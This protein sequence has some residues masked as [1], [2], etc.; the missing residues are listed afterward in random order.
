MVGIMGRIHPTAII[1][2]GALLADDVEIGPYCIIDS[3]NVRIGAGTRL[4]ANVHITGNVTIG[5]GNLIYPYAAIGFEPQDRKFSL[6]R[7]SAGVKIGNNNVLREGVTIHCATQAKP[8]TLGDDNFLM[9]Y[10]HLGH[11][12]QM[13]NC[14]TLANSTLLAG[15]VEV[16]NNVVTGGGSVVHQF[17]RLGRLA[18]LSGVAGIV[19]DLPPFCTCYST[20]FVESLNIVGLRRAGC[21]DHIPALKQAFEILYRGRHTLPTAADQIEHELG[22]DP[23]CQEFAAFVRSSKRGITPYRD[24]QTAEA[25]FPAE[26][27]V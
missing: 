17:C 13:G 5:S 16:A 25:S 10:A 1:H 15:H 19:Q 21:R 27:R 12:V 4:M 24:T 2:S 9:C 6:G 14:C 23:L 20:R 22:D 8:T 26:N 11:D 18:M 7:A 3:P